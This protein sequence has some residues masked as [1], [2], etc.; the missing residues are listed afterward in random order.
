[1]R[2]NM[3]KENK[4]II[5]TAD[6]KKI[7]EFNEE[8]FNEFNYLKVTKIEDGEKKEVRVLKMTS[9]KHLIMS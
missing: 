9:N 8:E 2:S 4:V 7:V 1:M 6:G 3:G 5:E